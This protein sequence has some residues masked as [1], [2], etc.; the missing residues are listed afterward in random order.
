MADLLCL[1]CELSQRMLGPQLIYKDV[2]EAM[3]LEVKAIHGLGELVNL[4]QNCLKNRS[5]TGPKLYLKR[6]RC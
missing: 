3:V 6:F 4:I 2:L 1:A 5:I